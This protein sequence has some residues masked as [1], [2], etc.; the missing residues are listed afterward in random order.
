MAHTVESLVDKRQ[1]RSIGICHHSLGNIVEGSA[2]F[3]IVMIEKD[4]VYIYIS[5][6]GIYETN[7]CRT[8]V[9]E[10]ELAG[11]TCLA[12]VIHRQPVPT[13]IDR[14]FCTERSGSSGWSNLHLV[15]TVY[16]NIVKIEHAA[17]VQ[18]NIACAVPLAFYLPIAKVVLAE[19]L[20]FGLFRKTVFNGIGCEFLNFCTC[21]CFFADTL[22]VVAHGVAQDC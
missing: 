7:K 8:M 13:T 17:L 2:L 19:V 4:S 12:L 20:P 22:Q 18:R 16:Q 15:Q 9:V 3:A 5:F 10:C 1:W 11:S 14:I 21:C 6:G